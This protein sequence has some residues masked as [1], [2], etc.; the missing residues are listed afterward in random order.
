[1]LCYVF[2]FN[3]NENE[4]KFEKQDKLVSLRQMSPG[5]LDK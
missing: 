5:E 1:M 4:P 2:L 3:K